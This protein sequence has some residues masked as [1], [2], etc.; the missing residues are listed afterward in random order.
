MLTADKAGVF[1]QDSHGWLFAWKNVA[2][3]SKAMNWYG[4]TGSGS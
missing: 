1:R 2:G 3:P 4:T